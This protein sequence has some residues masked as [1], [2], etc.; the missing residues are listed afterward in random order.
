M[1]RMLRSTYFS[2]PCT[3]VYVASTGIWSSQCTQMIC[4]VPFI[5][6]RPATIKDSWNP[7]PISTWKTILNR[8]LRQ[9]YVST[10]DNT[11]WV[12]NCISSVI[13]QASCKAGVL[14]SDWSS[15]Q[16]SRRRSGYHSGQPVSSC[17][18]CVSEMKSSTLNKWSEV[19]KTM[20]NLEEL[21]QSETL[22]HTGHLENPRGIECFEALAKL[23][24]EIPVP[25][26]IP[27]NYE[28]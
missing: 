3:K 2:L 28:S 5:V 6:R 17:P 8:D 1:S 25:A 10:Q 4:L 22:L 16:P 7:S 20:C 19:D 14:H 18:F 15:L 13:P 11:Y 26:E 24:S 9:G 21:V 12:Q 27:C 23:C